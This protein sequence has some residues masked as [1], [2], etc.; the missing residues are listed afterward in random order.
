MGLGQSFASEVLKNLAI[1]GFRN[2]YLYDKHSVDSDD[3]KYGFYYN[4]V[5]K[6]NSRVD[7]LKK[8]I[9]ELNPTTIISEGSKEIMKDLDIMVLLNQPYEIIFNFEKTFEGKLIVGYCTGINGFVFVNPKEHITNDVNG[10]NV[11]SH[12]IKSIIIEDERTI[13]ETITK[14]DLSYGDKITFENM[15]LTESFDFKEKYKVEVINVYK[16]SVEPLEN[17]KFINGSIL[18]TKEYV[19]FNDYKSFEESID[20]P[21][22]EGFDYESSQKVIDSYQHILKF[23]QP[24]VMPVV[25]VVGSLV[26]MK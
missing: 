13:I 10:E 24:Q 11:V 2:F 6:S 22:F 4:S 12:N 7:S 20:S 21:K 25:S 18:K 17:I 3:I 14:H 1:S 26:I 23:L 16:F 5:D 19:T 8:K 9:N 15:T